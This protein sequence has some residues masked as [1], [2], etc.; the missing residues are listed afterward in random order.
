MGTSATLTNV[1]LDTFWANYSP[2]AV[3]SA[4]VPARP[5]HTSGADG[6]RSCC[7]RS[8]PPG[9]GGLGRDAQQGGRRQAWG[10]RAWEPPHALGCF[11]G[12][13]ATGC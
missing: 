7:A 6:C 10:W 11:P 4:V 13:A 3:V 5:V 2:T 1:L 12:T 8:A 9:L